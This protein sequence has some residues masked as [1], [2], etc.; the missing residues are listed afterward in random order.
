MFLDAQ[1]ECN[2]KNEHNDGKYGFLWEKDIDSSS[3]FFCV[4]NV[5]I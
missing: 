3:I 4:M 2:Y 1:I 5:K